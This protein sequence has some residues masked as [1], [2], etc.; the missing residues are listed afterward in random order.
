MR[1]PIRATALT[2]T[3][4]FALGC[5]KGSEPSKAT[6][7]S[8]PQAVPTLEAG[9]KIG[10]L[11]PENKTARYEAFDKPIIE[12]RV[13]A[14]CP[15]CTVLY[16]N[17]QQDVARQET[18]ADSLLSQGVA[19]I[20]LDAVDSAA[21]ASIVAKAKEKQVPVISYDRFAS[22]PVD[23]FI[24]F[25]SFKVGEA[26]GRNLLDRISK[27]GDPKRG[28]VVMLNGSVT[29]PNAADYKKGA[30]S[31]L[32]GKV[33]IG[34][35]A[36]TPGWSPE[37]GQ[38]EM[39]EAITKLGQGKIIGVYAANDGLGG[40]A[41]TA[42]KAHGV[43][44]LPPVTGQDAEL[45]AIQ[46]I[47]SGDQYMTVYKPVP[48]EAEATAKIAV[49]IATGHKYEGTTVEMVNASNHKVPSVLLPVVAVTRETVGDIIVKGKVYKA[50]DICTEPL[51]AACKQVGL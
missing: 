38:Q 27:D 46:R 49:A 3:A 10:L 18:Q 13:Q 30:H 6:A 22:G 51:A 7:T 19:V 23:Y 34:F 21:A 12:A 5:S 48:D 35:E 42:L 15:K 44:P 9:F 24:T 8:G 47:V 41:I 4:L 14:L 37:K 11:L 31:V 28:A 32:D 20:I 50:S 29:D 16:E 26:Q 1:K 36:D 40:A 33:Q 17:A 25:D 39:E 43:T 45:A 2:L